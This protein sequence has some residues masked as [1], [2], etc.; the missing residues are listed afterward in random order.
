[1]EC[2]ALRPLCQAAQVLPVPLPGASSTAALAA[3][4]TARAECHDIRTQAA[5]TLD[6]YND[7]VRWV[8][9]TARLLAPLLASEQIDHLVTSPRSWVLQG[10][11]P[12]AHGDL[13]GL[14][15]LELEI[16]EEGLS[17]AIAELQAAVSQH[18]LNPG[19]LVV[20]DTNVYLH[21]PKPFD[22]EDWPDL[23]PG[24][25][26]HVKLVIPLVVVDELDQHKMA[27][28]AGRSDE[29]AASWL[30]AGLEVFCES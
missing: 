6:R 2:G 1:M 3:L 17:V 20:L 25:P 19:E 7:Y 30:G 28:P 9:R 22:Q 4:A 24:G 16:R 8:N 14:V 23:L 11:D 10:L 5:H 27:D 26:T 29:T 15:E 12:G 18:K 21:H 13:A